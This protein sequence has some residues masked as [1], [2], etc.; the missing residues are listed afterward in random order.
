MAW[1]LVRQKLKVVQQAPCGPY[2]IDV[3]IWPVA[4][5]VHSSDTAPERYPHLMSRAQYLIEHGWSVFYLWLGRHGKF[6]T[7]KWGTPS[8]IAF[9]RHQVLAG[10]A[11]PFRMSRIGGVPHDEGEIVDGRLVVGIAPDPLPE[12]FTS[13]LAHSIWA[14]LSDEERAAWKRRET[15]LC[16]TGGVEPYEKTPIVVGRGY[17][18]RKIW[19]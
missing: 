7:G 17:Y 11:R 2:R 8:E 12:N 9:Y 6:L 10:D 14:A 3:G 5:E 18:R 4:V 15:Q 1:H 16:P 19:I 13:P